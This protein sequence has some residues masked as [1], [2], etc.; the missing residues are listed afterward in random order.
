MTFERYYVLLL[1]YTTYI[2]HFI[3]SL[4]LGETENSF[5][6]ENALKTVISDEKV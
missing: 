6:D 3:I 1:D 4:Q 2:C 5:S